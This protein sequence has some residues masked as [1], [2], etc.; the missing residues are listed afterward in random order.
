MHLNLGNGRPFV[1]EVLCPAFKPTVEGLSKAL[2]CINSGTGLNLRHD[3]EVT[4]ISEVLL[5]Y[6]YR[7]FT[8]LAT[9]PFVH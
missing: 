7:S 6:S 8:L 4:W 3:I 1:L 9:G 2:N 5:I